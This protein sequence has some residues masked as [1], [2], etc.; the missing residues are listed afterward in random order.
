MVANSLRVAVW[1]SGSFISFNA[2]WLLGESSSFNS[3]RFSGLRLKKAFSEQ[4]KRADIPRKSKMINKPIN[5]EVMD[6]LISAMNK[7]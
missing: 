3:A 4:E 7:G 6:K 2:M 5:K 1:R